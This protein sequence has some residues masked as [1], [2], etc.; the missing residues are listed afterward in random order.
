MASA[1]MER[2]NG[3]AT[4]EYRREPAARVRTG[5]EK[6]AMKAPLS[7]RLMR[8]LD[9]YYDCLAAMEEEAGVARR[10]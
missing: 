9:G 6:A 7:T 2:T 8:E 1:T 3:T 10:G 5:G 4:L